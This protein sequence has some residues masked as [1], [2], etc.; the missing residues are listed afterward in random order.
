MESSIEE[1]SG[2]MIALLA[3]ADVV[4]FILHFPMSEF[5]FKIIESWC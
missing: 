3:M 1:I 2:I 4:L 5:V